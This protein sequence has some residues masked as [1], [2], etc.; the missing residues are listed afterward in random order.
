MGDGSGRNRHQHD[1]VEPALVVH[2]QRLLHVISS[3]G[4]MLFLPRQFNRTLLL[5]CLFAACLFQTT[6]PPWR[7]SQVRN[8]IH[9]GGSRTNSLWS[10]RSPKLARILELELV[11]K[12]DDARA[13]FFRC[14]GSARLVS[15]LKSRAFGHLGLEE[16]GL[17]QRQDESP[18]DCSPLTWI[19]ATVAP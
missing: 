2:D 8:A 9:E 18:V 6:N 1:P 16:A 17:S 13:C 10:V 5:R 12:S 4:S 15:V 3:R 14:D 19:I 7:Q 11:G